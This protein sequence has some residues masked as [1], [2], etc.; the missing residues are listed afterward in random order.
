MDCFKVTFCLALLV[1]AAFATSSSTSPA[2][3]AAS[4]TVDR[5]PG[6]FKHVKSVKVVGANNTSSS[7]NPASITTPDDNSGLETW[8]IALIA[9][10][11][12]LVVAAIAAIIIAA[13]ACNKHKKKNSSS[14]D[15][16][17]QES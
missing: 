5:C 12:V 17:L 7:K 11:G 3:M 6:I 4:S 15:I 14:K 1:L 13:V 10:G 8:H 2:S 9:V 16:E